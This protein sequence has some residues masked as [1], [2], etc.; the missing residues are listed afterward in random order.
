LSK[1][2]P[3]ESDTVQQFIR[4]RQLTLMHRAIATLTTA[5]DDEL[6]F[7]FHRLGGSLGSYQL[8]AAATL[9][10]QLESRAAAGGLHASLDSIRAE[11]VLGLRAITHAM[12]SVA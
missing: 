5:P 6:A 7:Q 1:R 3:S 9:L 10:M 4:D 8:H 2:R 11:A 12:E